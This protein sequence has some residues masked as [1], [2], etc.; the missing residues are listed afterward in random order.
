DEAANSAVYQ[1]PTDANNRN[2]AGQLQKCGESAI[3]WGSSSTA[4]F[5]S[6][7]PAANAT[8]DMTDANN[9]KFNLSM[10]AEQHINVDYE[11]TSNVYG[12][13]PE[14]NGC[15]MYARTTGVTNGTTVNLAY[16]PF[17]TALRFKLR[18]PQPT[19]S[20][21]EPPIRVT[22]VELHSPYVIAGDFTAT[23][24]KAGGS[25]VLETRGKTSQDIT[26]IALHEGT[27]AYLTLGQGESVELSAFLN[28]P[29]DVTTPVIDDNWYIKVTLSDRTVKT[30]S[31]GTKNQSGNKN[32]L[33]RGM[34]HRLDDLPYLSEA[35]W[36]ANEWMIHVARNVYLSEVSLPGSW[37]SLNS[38]FQ[39]QGTDYAATIAAQYNV[40]CRAFHI[41]TRWKGDATH[42]TLNY[43][44]RYIGSSGDYSK[45]DV[46]NLSVANGTT[47]YNIHYRWKNDL[48]VDYAT[49]DGKIM[50]KDNPKFEDVL[51]AITSHANNEEYMVVVCTFA[52]NSFQHNSQYVNYRSWMQAVSDA[53]ANNET[54]YDAR[55]LTSNTVVGDVL[56]KVIVIAN[57]E[58]NVSD[59]DLRTDSK[60]L[61][62]NA[63]LTLTE[64]MFSSTATYNSG[65][66]YK[67]DKSITDVRLFNTQAQIMNTG[68]GA[69]GGDRGY[70]PSFDQRKR[71]AGNI[72][73][74]A[75][76]NYTGSSTNYAH[77][78][79]IY[80]G[81]GGYL[82]GDSG[83]PNDYNR[84]TYV[85]NNLNNWI[86]DKVEA[87]RTDKKYYPVG[88][89]LM[90]FVTNDT[91]GRPVVENIF[92]LNNLYR[93]A[94]D[95]ARS[96]EDGEYT[97]ADVN[98]V[99]PGYDS[100][101]IDNNVNAISA[102]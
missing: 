82:D 17:S 20:G 5:Y 58:G 95:P 36:N 23:L 9:V 55:H 19:T 28:I 100:G 83:I 96:P 35:E 29:T 30:K 60:C 24:P 8:V 42:G 94:Y 44:Y 88:I 91:Y 34:I 92:K 87:M 64:A 85:A 13:K 97:A 46:N 48:N 15:F 63:P 59:M 69:D 52:Q 65:D 99:A 7:Y 10:P 76:D 41:D 101:M 67:G 3:W 33:V 45:S 14:M 51:S 16:Q 72:L 74:W 32:V 1:V 50:G 18:G 86:N 93:M 21:G 22:K 40:G 70:K 73:N 98:S 49:Q 102:D 62:V 37:N 54:I 66:F 90:N 79:W 47:A 31:L 6:V 43:Y 80:L 78:S 38:D 27:S 84:Y 56:G 68:S 81:L 2:Y 12:A 89:V 71:I 11:P 4:D 26:L 25:P 75:K 77:D 39:T 61:F 57:C 53:C